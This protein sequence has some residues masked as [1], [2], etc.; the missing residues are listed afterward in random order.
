M[1]YFV[2]F[3]IDG[4]TKVLALIGNPV[5]HSLSPMIHN[6]ISEQLGQNYVY[7]AL[8]VE[9]DD[10]KDAIDGMRALGIRGFNVTAPHKIRVMEYLDKISPEAQKEHSV[11]TIVNKDGVLCGY[12]TDAEGFFRSLASDGIEVTD[13][14]ILIL[15]A[16]GVAKPIVLRLIEEKPASVTILNRTP[17][18]AYNLA[19]EIYTQTGYKVETEV[20]KLDFDIVINTTSAGMADKKDVLP[21]D[22]I[23]EIPNLDFVNENTVAV[24]LIYRPS[25]T[26]F[27]E[28]CE[29]RGAKIQNGLG[30]LVWQAVVAYELFTDVTVDRETVNKL[31]NKIKEQI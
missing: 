11:N 9:N 23:E 28:E 6:F 19:K 8:C 29:K 7:S 14:N 17:Q 21:T 30:M 2:M 15:G 18:K 13:K 24:D 4:H 31:M 26:R 12:S 5:E 1:G 16:G 3:D 25:K 22:S 27:L 10:V 20:N